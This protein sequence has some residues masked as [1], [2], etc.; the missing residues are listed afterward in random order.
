[1]S[2]RT[3]SGGEG[4]ERRPPERNTQ[5]PYK[6]AKKK[7]K[8]FRWRGGEEGENRAKERDKLLRTET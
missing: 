4:P 8:K 1:M 7:R 3:L 2:H 5:R 6:T